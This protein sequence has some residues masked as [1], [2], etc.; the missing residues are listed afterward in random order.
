MLVQKHPWFLKYKFSY[1]KNLHL[2]LFFRLNH[3]LIQLEQILQSLF[4]AIK[5]L[6]SIALFYRQIHFV[7]CLAQTCWH[8]IGIV[9]LCHGFFG[10]LFAFVQYFEN[11]AFEGG[12][13]CLGN[14]WEREC[15]VAEG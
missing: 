4:V 14:V 12:F 3:F 15:V 6:F 1:V 13:L 2:L 7:M 5:W 11:M 10:V 8:F 9:E